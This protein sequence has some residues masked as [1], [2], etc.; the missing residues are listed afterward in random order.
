[1][2]ADG[3]MEDAQGRLV[4]LDQIKEIDMARHELVMELVEQFQTMREQMRAL[5]AR[6]M[7]DVE[8]FVQMSAELYGANIGGKRAM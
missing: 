6:I 3:Y 1:M 2:K 7:D 5:K 4:P 8:S